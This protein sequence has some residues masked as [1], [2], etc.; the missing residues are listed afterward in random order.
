MDKIE[1]K[2]GDIVVCVLSG[3]YGK[4]RPMIKKHIRCHAVA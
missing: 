1:I 4:P 2:K 3:D